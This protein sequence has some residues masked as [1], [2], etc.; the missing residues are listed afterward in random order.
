MSNL[1][2]LDFYSKHWARL[3]SQRYCPF[4]NLNQELYID[5]HHNVLYSIEQWPR[6]WCLVDNAYYY[7]TKGPAARITVLV[8]DK[9]SVG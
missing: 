6:C 2:L 8:D 7:L 1:C 3:Y 4:C 5:E 9:Y